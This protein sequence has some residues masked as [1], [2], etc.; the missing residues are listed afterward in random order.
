[1]H[2]EGAQRC[3]DGLANPNNAFFNAPTEKRNPNSAAN[4]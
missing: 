3:L 2:I 1:L 4:E